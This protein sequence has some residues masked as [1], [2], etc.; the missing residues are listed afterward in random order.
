[1]I[2]KLPTSL[3]SLA[4]VFFVSILVA[5]MGI[6]VAKAYD[7]DFF[8]DNDIL[9]YDPDAC[10]VESTG[11]GGDIALQGNDIAEKVFRFLTGTSFASFGNKPFNALQAAGALGNFQQESTMDPGAVEPS[12]GTGIG[13]AQWSSANGNQRKATLIQLA[14]SM[15]KKSGD[16]EPQIKMMENELNG[17]YGA[18]LLKAGFNS[19]STPQQASYIFQKV[20]EGAGTPNQ[21][22]RDSAAASYYEKYKSIA[23]S[24]VDTSTTG[25]T[26]DPAAASKCAPTASTSNFAA[27]GFVIYNQFDPQWAKLPYG[28]TTIAAAGCGPS[29]MAMVITALTGQSVTPKDTTAYADSKGMYTAAGSSWA[30][31]RVV[32]EHWGL[33]AN[34]IANTVAAVN[35]VLN[36]GGLVVTSG[37]GATPFT[38]GGH[39][40]TIRGVT[41]S[42]KWKI[43]DSN[44]NIGGQ[45]S[46]KE[47]DPQQILDI[48]N[49]GNV[50]AITK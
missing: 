48:A 23:P 12:P 13:L 16:L 6:Q 3:K 20:Y 36:A 30:I 42:G 44:G 14:A 18:S 39:Y 45:N 26:T 5:S 2:Q 25:S 41:S 1:M 33:K 9:F 11:G 31:A 4:A 21:A 49:A 24:P 19:V 34:N 37:R 46:N 15:G 38:S 28:S 7:V 32:A 22:K 47:W 35:A 27:D 40:I 43:G 10:Q 50:V 29:S 8:S 17:P